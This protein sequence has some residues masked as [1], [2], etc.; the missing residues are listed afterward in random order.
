MEWIANVEAL[1]R[2]P[3][4]HLAGLA[5]LVSTNHD[6]VGLIAETKNRGHSGVDAAHQ[7]RD[8]FAVGIAT[9]QR[10]VAVSRQV[11]TH[12]RVHRL[13]RRRPAKPF[14]TQETLLAV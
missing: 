10:D 7:R 12:E 9:Q 1:N 2:F 3:A 11:A 5:D 8:K 13:R 6:P 4:E 14:A